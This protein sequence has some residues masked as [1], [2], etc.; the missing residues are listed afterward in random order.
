MQET[1]EIIVVLDLLG[2]EKKEERITNAKVKIKE[3]ARK[4][5]FLA[6]AIRSIKGDLLNW[7]N[8][9]DHQSTWKQSFKRV[10]LLPAQMVSVLVLCACMLIAY[11]VVDGLD[12]ERIE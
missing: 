6:S 2:E 3:T 11:L 8:P 5:F 10:V 12:E 7:W 9:D 4:Q 1:E